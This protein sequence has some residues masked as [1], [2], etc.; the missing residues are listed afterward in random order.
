MQS[1]IKIGELHFRKSPCESCGREEA[2]SDCLTF[3]FR[4]DLEVVAQYLN[5][6]GQME[7]RSQTEKYI[8]DVPTYHIDSKILINSQTQTT[9]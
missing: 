3:S 4:T 2:N 8:L 7:A 6:Q 1:F 9:H 5:L